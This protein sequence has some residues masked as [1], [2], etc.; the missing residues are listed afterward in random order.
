LNR[1][2]EGLSRRGDGRRVWP[3]GVAAIIVSLRKLTLI[4]TVT[5]V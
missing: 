5:A 2:A 1:L 3:I 4:A